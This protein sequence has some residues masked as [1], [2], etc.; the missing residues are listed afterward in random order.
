MLKLSF[1]VYHNARSVQASLPPPRPNF[2]TTNINHHLFDDIPVDSRQ[3]M[4]AVRVGFLNEGVN[5]CLFG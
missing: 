5:Q 2:T 1:I 3:E 4:L